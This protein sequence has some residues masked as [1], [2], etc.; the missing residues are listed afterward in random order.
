MVDRNESVSR[1][2]AHSGGFPRFV[3]YPASVVGCM[4]EYPAIG[5]RFAAVVTR[6]AMFQGCPAKLQ[7][8]LALLFFHLTALVDDV[9]HLIRFGFA[10]HH[11]VMLVMAGRS[12]FEKSNAS[13]NR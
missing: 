3:V 6:A 2:I 7:R 9:G 1:T 5:Q 10:I 11:S 4:A 13:V 8:L 12:G